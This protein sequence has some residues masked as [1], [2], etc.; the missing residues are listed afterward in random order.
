MVLT[1]KDELQLKELGISLEEAHRQL[2]LL[3]TPPAPAHLLRACTAD[4]GV[5]R[6][7]SSERR[8]SEE[9]FEQAVARGRVTKFVPAS[10]A[11]SRM[12]QRLVPFL[13]ADGEAR[14]DLLEKR[15]AQGDSAAQDLLTLG[16]ELPRFAFHAPLVGALEH[17]GIDLRQILREGDLRQLLRA[18]LE[19]EGLGYGAAPKGLIPFHSYS[20]G[21]RTA[22]EEHLTE[23][24]AY[25]RDQ[26]GACR[27]HFTVAAEAVEKFRA[28]EAGTQ[29]RLQDLRPG[30]PLSFK[31]GYSV[32]APAT[33][34]L[35][36]DAEDRPFRRP[37][38]SLLLRPGGHGSLLRNLQATHGDLVLIKNIDNVVPDAAKA[39]TIQW[40]KILGGY[41]ASLQEEVFSCQQRL[42][43]GPDATQDALELLVQRLGLDAASIP[44][45]QGRQAFARQLLFR[46]IRVC[47]VVANT[48]ETGG[49]PFW[50]RSADGTSKQIVEGAQIAGAGLGGCAMVLVQATA[51]AT[52]KDRLDRLF[53]TPKHFPSGVIECIPAAGSCLV[54]IASEGAVVV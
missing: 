1:P 6:L 37:D 7:S 47:G 49:G 10:G 30:E 35:A 44:T 16:A 48:G 40:K 31:I 50:V 25:T 4:D 24:E 52:L 21:P 42:E 41:L 26:Q 33:G 45:A 13:Q 39:Q 19:E 54:S 9:K 38:G 29:E 15:A 22:F 43:E 51:V 27:L 5:L 3:A 17:R 12:F 36:L 8:L 28:L 11:A 2:H 53:Y 20:E 34:T 32:Q 23:A 14:R 18:L 46:P